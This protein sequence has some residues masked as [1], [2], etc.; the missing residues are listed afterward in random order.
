MTVTNVGKGKIASLINSALGNGELGTSTQ[1][2]SVTDTNLISGVS[3][4]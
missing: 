2:P 1:E 3:E 4:Q